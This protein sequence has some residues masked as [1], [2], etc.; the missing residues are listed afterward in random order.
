M[1]LTILPLDDARVGILAD[2]A[3][4]KSH[5]I[6]PVKTVGRNSYA[7]RSA[8]TLRSSVESGEVI[9]DKDMT[10]IL[11]SDGIRA[12]IIV[13]HIHEESGDSG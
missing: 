7:E 13:G 9:V 5:D 12:G 1:E 11:E 4:F 6:V 10:A 8:H 2:G 3:V